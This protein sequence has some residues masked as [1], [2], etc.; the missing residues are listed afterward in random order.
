MLLTQIR[1]L[2]HSEAREDPSDRIVKHT[3]DDP[4]DLSAEDIWQHHQS[5]QS[6]VALRYWQWYQS[7]C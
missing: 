5:K 2:V 1:S 3:Q 7:V 4:S 6:D